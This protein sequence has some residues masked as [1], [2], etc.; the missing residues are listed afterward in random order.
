MKN[1]IIRLQMF[2]T[3]GD[4]AALKPWQM[5]GVNA[6]LRELD[7]L[8]LTT[9]KKTVLSSHEIK[10]AISS[11]R[12]KGLK[13]TVIRNYLYGI[14]SVATSWG[15]DILAEEIARLSLHLRIEKKA[16]NRSFAD[17]AKSIQCKATTPSLGDGDTT[18]ILIFAVN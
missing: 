9:S 4:G 12:I 15:Y 14:R 3:L 1:Y 13:P 11:W 5:V 10:Q 17:E 7:Y 16:A 18:I 2:K 6:L 8:G